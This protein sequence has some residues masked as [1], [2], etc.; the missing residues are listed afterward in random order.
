MIEERDVIGLT[1]LH[2]NPGIHNFEKVFEK[3]RK[4]KVETDTVNGN[5]NTPE[6]NN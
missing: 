3:P 4:R 5:E 6:Q 1:S 2:E